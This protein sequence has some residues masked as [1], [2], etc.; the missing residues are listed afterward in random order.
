MQVFH[1]KQPLHLTGGANVEGRAEHFYLPILF[2][3]VNLAFFP[4]GT[5]WL[6]M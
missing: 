6:E 2:I 1:T 4:K 5:A 3:P